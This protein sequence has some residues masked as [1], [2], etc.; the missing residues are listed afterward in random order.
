MAF[1]I[2]HVAII[3]LA[4]FIVVSLVY[5]LVP[6][7]FAPRLQGYISMFAIVGTFLAVASFFITQQEQQTQ[8][9]QNSLQQSLA[10]I[11]T[12]WIAIEQ[13]FSANPDLQNMYKGLNLDNVE[14][15]KLPDVPITDQSKYKEIHVA[16]WLIQII[17]NINTLVESKKLNWGN[18]SLL[19]WLSIFRSWF[20][21][22]VMKQQWAYLQKFSTPSMQELVNHRIL[23]V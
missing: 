12:N 4:I 15:Q 5:W 7:T 19:A 22:P 2:G 23:G 11:Q 10:F 6:K 1:Q 13:Y 20:R 21:Y 17:E 3:L 8:A 14:L 16:A 9:Q 18:P